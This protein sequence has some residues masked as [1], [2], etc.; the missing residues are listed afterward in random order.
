MS[1]MISLASVVNV[2][3]LKMGFNAVYPKNLD[4]PTM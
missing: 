1:H 2:V 4:Q 3:C